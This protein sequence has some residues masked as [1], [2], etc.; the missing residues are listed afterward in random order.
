MLAAGDDGALTCRVSV[1]AALAMMVAGCY[2]PMAQTAD[3][4]MPTEFV[5][6]AD[7]IWEYTPNFD[8]WHHDVETIPVKIWGQPGS[9]EDREKCAKAC[10]EHPTCVSFNFPHPIFPGPESKHWHDP[11]VCYLKSTRMHSKK[12]GLSCEKGFHSQIWMYFSLVEDQV[13][14]REVDGLLAERWPYEAQVQ[15]PRALDSSIRWVAGSRW[16]MTKGDECF[17][18]HLVSVNLDTQA[19]M[20]SQLEACA[21][22]CQAEQDCIAFGFPELQPGG[23]WDA[24]HEGPFACVL[25]QGTAQNLEN[26]SVCKSPFGPW[27]HYT[28]ADAWYVHRDHHHEYVRKPLPPRVW[29]GDKGSPCTELSGTWGMELHHVDADVLETRRLAEAEEDDHA[30]AKCCLYAAF[31]CGADVHSSCEPLQSFPVGCKG[32]CSAAR[33]KCHCYTEELEPTDDCCTSCDVSCGNATKSNCLPAGCAGPQK[34]CP[35]HLG[36]GSA[37]VC[38]APPPDVAAGWNPKTRTWGTPVGMTQVP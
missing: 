12:L 2:A 11:Q 36:I 30:E 24:E 7:A 19:A 29:H 5:T 18:M 21:A 25:K 17:G 37:C 4:E 31:R 16:L 34:M 22:R 32:I 27:N 8:C 15:L 6:I 14:K 3:V 35:S 1:K 9:I 13:W 33:A 20:Q 26:I 28:M 10:L 23:A 38:E